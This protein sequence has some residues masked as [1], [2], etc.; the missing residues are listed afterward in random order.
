MEV[1]LTMS[2]DRS[3][4]VSILA[5]KRWVDRLERRVIEWGVPRSKLVRDAVDRLILSA[6]SPS[7]LY[8]APR[9]PKAIRSVGRLEE[10]IDK[11]K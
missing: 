6:R 3:V 9:R 5:S 4:I 7:D 10:P 1:V 11:H 8:G 2:R